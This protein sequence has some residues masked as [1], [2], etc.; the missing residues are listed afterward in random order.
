M[1]R[2]T[3]LWL[4]SIAL[5]ALIASAGA[6]TW[7][8]TANGGGDAGLTA[9]TA[10]IIAGNPNDP[11]TTITG[12]IDT[13]DFADVELLVDPYFPRTFGTVEPALRGR[14]VHRGGRNRL[15]LDG[16]IRWLRDMRT[17]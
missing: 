16:H 4:S 10:Q 6:N 12:R 8:E 17:E 11:L 7:D 3:L 9:G 2:H 5:A 13:N 1:L 15:F 14:S